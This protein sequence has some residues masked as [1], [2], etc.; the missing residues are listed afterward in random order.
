MRIAVAVLFVVFAGSSRA[1]CVATLPLQG[2]ETAPACNDH[3]PGC[4]PAAER[5]FEYLEK[6]PDSPSVVTIALQSSPWRM[7]DPDLRILTVEELAAT[8]RPHLEDGV[9]KVQ[10]VG[11]WTAVAPS[12]KQPALTEQVSRALDGFPVEGFE[13][14][15]WVSPNGELR[16]SRQAFTMRAGDG[17]YGVRDGDEVMVAL[18]AGW[19]TTV[20]SHWI[21]QRNAEGVMR[22]GVGWDVFG[23]CPDRALA[24]FEK[25]AEL[26]SPIGAYNAAIM[27]LE[28]GGSSNQKEALV[29]LERAAAL[30]D[31][32]AIEKL[33][34]L[35][36]Q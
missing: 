34:S 24:S 13:G 4:H 28:R 29:W 19:H 15:L 25:S 22:A 18:V 10:L 12:D 36:K 26:G 2:T 30:G 16:T 11:S 21:E 27:R 17:P 5:L 6:I 9:R 35:A 31:A 8:I 20:E 23:L 1:D 7:Y 33:A 14:F 32:K 3:Q